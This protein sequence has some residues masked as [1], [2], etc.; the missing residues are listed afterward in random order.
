MAIANGL[1]E[2]GL[3]IVAIP[4]TIDNDIPGTDRCFGFDTAV[5][6][7]TEALDRLHTTAQSHHRVMILE[8]M[9]RYAGWIALFAGVA[10]GA[11]V[12]L[13]PEI[14]Y[15]IDEVARVCREREM[16]GRRSTLV[17]IAE[18]ARAVGGEVEVRHVDDATRRERLGGIGYRVEEALRERIRSEVRTTVLGHV[19][20]G[21]TPSAFDRNL[22]TAL[23]SYAATL[24]AEGQF[25][26]M[27]AIRDNHLRA[28]PLAE[29]VGQ[30]RP[31]PTNAPMLAA[32]LAV[33][34]SFGTRTLD[35][36]TWQR[37]DTV[38]FIG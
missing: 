16:G 24:V 1:Q 12:I 13:I 32:A 4:K 36:T 21:G 9:G 26:Q 28:V 38:P 15:D 22:A 34:T 25:G 31:V 6:V 8:T 33:G 27:V 29:V 23:G 2:R 5:G 7:A 30:H 3:N 37:A 18:G 14:E 20:R 10:G 35:P 17:C 19:Q 11:D